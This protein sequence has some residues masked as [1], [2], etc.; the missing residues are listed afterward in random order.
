MA[1]SR[2]G[3]GTPQFGTSTSILS[4]TSQC[5]PHP[6][7]QQLHPS[8][9][10]AKHL[11]STLTPL[12][13]TPH[14]QSVGE[15]CSLYLQNIS[16]IQP[17]LT[18]PS[19][20]PKLPSYGLDFGNSLLNTSAS[21]PHTQVSKKAAKV[22]FWKP[23][24]H[25][26]TPP[27]ASISLGVKSKPNPRNGGQGTGLLSLGLQLPPNSLTPS[28]RTAGPLAPPPTTKQI[29]HKV[30]AFA[31]RLAQ[32]TLPEIHMADCLIPWN[33]FFSVGLSLTILFKVCPPHIPCPSSLP[34]FSP[35]QS[36]HILTH[37]IIHMFIHLLSVSPA[38]MGVPRGQ[39]FLNALI[40]AMCSTPRTVPGTWQVFKKCVEK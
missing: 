35:K 3:R 17:P 33:L 12:T 11:R 5:L 21:P 36:D 7:K 15:S 4:N 30:S 16:R 26:A 34:Y 23:K 22:T 8:S 13:L 27:V 9:H 25:D 1:P 39:G 24:S 29:M 38:R 31:I 18:R 40:I 28:T 32:N 19:P 2:R 14:V 37:Y 10:Q 20:W 6:S